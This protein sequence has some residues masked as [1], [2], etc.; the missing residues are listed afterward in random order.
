MEKL[1]FVQVLSGRAD[2]QLEMLAGVPHSVAHSADGLGGSAREAEAILYWAGSRELL[3]AAFV[4]APNVRWVHSRSAGLDNMLFPELVESNVLLTNGSGVFSPSLGEFALAA[5]LYFAKDFRRMLRNQMA[6]R[7]EQFDVEEIAGQTVGIVG[8]GDIGRAVAGRVHAM[9]MRVV[10][11]KRHAPAAPDPLIAQ[12]YGPG[13]LNA[14]LGVCDY[15]VV[16]A[17]L[18]AETRHMISDAAF[19]AMKSNAVVINIGRGPVID[20]AALVRAL[21]EKRIKGAG[22]DVFEQEPIPAGDPIYQLENLLLSPHCA[23]HTKDWLDQAM[24]F[25]LEQYK[26]FARGEPLENVVEKHLGY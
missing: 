11:L 20:Q 12:F 16:A 2:R 22:L 4:A 14:M 3:R 23:D 15:V 26:R 10:A 17:P 25:F 13:E 8:Y 19:A 7:W 21:A 18:T 1:P 6:G 5:I 24:R 9:G